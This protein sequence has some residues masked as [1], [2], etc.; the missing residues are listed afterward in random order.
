MQELFGRGSH[1]PLGGTDKREG[2]VAAEGV[3]RERWL[4]QRSLERQIRKRGEGTTLGREKEDIQRGK[5][6]GRKKE[7]KGKRREESLAGED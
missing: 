2:K 1:R 7:K 3:V 6:K 5:K 4:W